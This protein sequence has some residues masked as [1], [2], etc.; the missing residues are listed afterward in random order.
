M[1]EF[2]VSEKLKFKFGNTDTT[3][4][5]AVSA[6]RSD[7]EA[8]NLALIGQTIIGQEVFLDKN[9]NLLTD[10]LSVYIEKTTR[11]LFL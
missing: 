7:L 6:P 5:I 10:L 4:D 2:I 1:D 3:R 9:G 8:E 11:Q